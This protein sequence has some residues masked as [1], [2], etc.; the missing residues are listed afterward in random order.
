M[1]QLSIELSDR[2]R[3]Q[4][5]TPPP[6]GRR[7]FDAM[8]RQLLPALAGGGALAALGWLC[9][10]SDEQPAGMAAAET[11]LAKGTRPSKMPAAIFCDMD[12]SV[13]NDEHAI[14]ACTQESFQRYRQSGGVIVFTTGR[15][16]E[17]LVAKCEVSEFWPE[18]C[19]A[20][21]GTTLLRPP[22]SRAHPAMDRLLQPGSKKHFFVG[23]QMV[24][25]FVA[26]WSAKI[27]GIHF[28]FDKVGDGP[29]VD[30][31][32]A[33]ASMCDG[34]KPGFSKEYA[35]R[36]AVKAA[37]PPSTAVDDFCGELLAAE[38]VPGLV[39]WVRGKG[40][41]EMMQ[42]LLDACESEAQR[43]ELGRLSI[44]PLGMNCEADGTNV[45]ILNSKLAG[46]APT[47]TWVCSQLGVATENV[48]A[49]GDGNNDTA[50]FQ[51]AG[52]SWCVFLPH[53]ASRVLI[54]G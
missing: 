13:L 12:G 44:E 6:A 47:L 7:C 28:W 24:S 2:T 51:A 21:A 18:L 14:S 10:R 48:W 52:W 39:V 20:S 43:A 5:L 23:S 30:S 19:I 46:K 17:S 53:F 22:K 45:V 33:M 9:L 42:A 16:L 36:A 41:S 50:M 4:S 40:H 38:E 32:E 8:D 15:N 26:L 49:F 3:S 1:L 35:H 34:Y 11:M 29:V 25:E 27:P 54:L 37:G 31:A